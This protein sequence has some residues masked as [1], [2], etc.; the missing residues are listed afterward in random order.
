MQGDTFDEAATDDT[1]TAEWGS[2]A[3]AGSSAREVSSQPGVGSGGEPEAMA[4]A[5]AHS[6]ERP[7]TPEYA[8]APPSSAPPSSRPPSFPSRAFPLVPFL[9]RA[10]EQHNVP[11]YGWLIGG[12]LGALL[13]AVVG[14][15]ALTGLAFGLV[16]HTRI[17]PVA[18]ATDAR[19]FKVSGAPD[20]AINNPSGNITITPGSAGAVHVEIV[21]RVQGQFGD[22]ARQTLDAI[23]V[24]MTQSGNA[25][26]VAVQFPKRDSFL[27]GE[28]TVDLTITTPV[29]SNLAIEAAAGD[30]TIGQITGKLD[31]SATA[32]SIKATGVSL[33]GAS[34]VVATA[35]DVT[36]D[37]L[38]ASGASLNIHVRAGNV[39]LRLPADTPARLNARATVGSLTV[40]GWPITVTHPSPQS[41][42]AQGPSAPNATA[43]GPLGANP[44]GVISVA[45]D[46]GNATIEAVAAK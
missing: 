45:V 19:T 46:S 30:L 38:L 39:L 7:A 9:V 40:T 4:L 37:G 1:S 31:I 17:G 24:N 21:K 22:N 8:S 2:P 34:S 27:G 33:M 14:C 15:C 29:N 26:T 25:V 23:H 11:W 16:G 41:P 20:L 28:R 6:R 13:L 42:G 36:L 5:E 18:T 10:R 43:A 32:G 12:A 44:S 3:R 35:G